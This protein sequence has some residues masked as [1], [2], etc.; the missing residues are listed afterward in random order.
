MKYSGVR[1]SPPTCRLRDRLG[2]THPVPGDATS[3]SP[4]SSSWSSLSSSAIRSPD[5]PG[6]LSPL[7]PRGRVASS[8]KANPARPADVPPPTS[9]AETGKRRV[10]YEVRFDNPQVRAKP[11]GCQSMNATNIDDV[12][13]CIIPCLHRGIVCVPTTLLI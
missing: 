6:G 7:Y 3:S 10:D 8:S 12:I 11:A 1:L 2:E 4:S 9:G 13:L 5:S